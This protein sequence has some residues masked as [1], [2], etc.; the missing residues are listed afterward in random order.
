[1]RSPRA[2]S[3]CS[4]TELLRPSGPWRSLEAIKYTALEWV[5]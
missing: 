2:S 1:M 5:E 4:K 3:G